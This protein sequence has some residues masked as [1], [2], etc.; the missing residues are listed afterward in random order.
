MYNPRVSFLAN[1]CEFC[2]ECCIL[3]WKLCLNRNNIEEILNLHIL[4]VHS[5][6]NTVIEWT[7]LTTENVHSPITSCSQDPTTDSETTNPELSRILQPI[8]LFSDKKKTIT[9]KQH[10]LIGRKI[11]EILSV[12]SFSEWVA[13]PKSW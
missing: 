8:G 7:L 1:M 10:I 3:A 12:H 9:N 4:Y 2:E 6:R 5:D 13:R 11:H